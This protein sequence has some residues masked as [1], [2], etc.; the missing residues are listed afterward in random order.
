MRDMGEQCSKH[1]VARL[2]RCEGIKAQ[3]AYGK[4]PRLRGGTPAVVA[5]NLRSQ[6][7]TMNAPNKVWVTDIARMRGGCI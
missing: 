5:P 6:Q 7:F 1:R 4:H 2:L 3:R